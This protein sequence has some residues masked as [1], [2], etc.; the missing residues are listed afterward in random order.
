M[1]VAKEDGEV[2]CSQ[3]AGGAPPLSGPPLSR[4]RR[5][6]EDNEKDVEIIRGV[7]KAG[8][9]RKL[10]YCMEQ[11]TNPQ[12]KIDSKQKREICVNDGDARTNEDIKE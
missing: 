10:N 3:H 11:E 2:G 4:G 6:R 7:V 1:H 9:I 8:Q 12:E 5:M